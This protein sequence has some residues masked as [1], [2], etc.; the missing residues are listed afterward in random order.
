MSSPTTDQGC[1]FNTSI[2]LYHYIYFEFRFYC[3]LQ[4]EVAHLRGIVNGGA[5]NDNWT[6]SFPGSPG[7][8]K[9]EGLHGLSSPLTSNKRISQVCKFFLYS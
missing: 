6:I 9:W 2:L 4:K 1:N 8:F 5:E 3:Y 7:S